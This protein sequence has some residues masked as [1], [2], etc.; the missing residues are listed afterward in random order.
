MK[1]VLLTA[2]ILLPLTVSCGKN[3]IIQSGLN[4]IHDGMAVV[5]KG[6][7]DAIDT[8]VKAF[9]D[10]DGE[11]KRA[12][13]KAKVFTDTSLTDA[14]QGLEKHSHSLVQGAGQ[15]GE[16]LG[17]IPRNILNDA[18]GTDSD[19]SQDIADLEDRVDALEA[20]MHNSFYDLSEEIQSLAVELRQAD[21]NLASSI[22][23]AI[24]KAE[25]ELA[26]EINRTTRNTN[27][28]N[29]AL[30]RIRGVKR[31]VRRI[32]RDLYNLEVVC[33]NITGF[34]FI[35]VTPVCEVQ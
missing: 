33:E 7:F 31:D 25:N 30:S 10:I 3:E 35:N 2:L 13:T 8:G 29:R 19:S 27:R 6:T 28:I 11:S 32:S 1:K 24:Q 14:R 21:S 23:D 26:V 16:S 4:E 15:V 20:E 9:Q 22:N 17:Q 18:L 5:S 12:F 34:L